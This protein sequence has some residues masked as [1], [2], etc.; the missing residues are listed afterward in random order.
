MS[1]LAALGLELVPAAPDE[2]AFI[3]DAW[4]S[5]YRSSPW[6]GTISNDRYQ[7]VQRWTINSL[8]ARGA[9][10]RVAI[11]A[12]PSLPRRIVGFVCYEAPSLLHYVYTKQSYRH[13]GVARGMISSAEEAS[14][15]HL[16]RLT[17]RTRASKSLLDAG[18]RWDPVPARTKDAR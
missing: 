7:E 17:H 8:I 2:V 16:S 6:A 12:D 15:S 14:S 10:L 5:S 18:F 9:E 4:C 11:P 13:K 3:L 1:K